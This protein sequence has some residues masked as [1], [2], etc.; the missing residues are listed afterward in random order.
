MFSQNVTTNLPIANLRSR[1]SFSNSQ[2]KNK[3]L[4]KQVHVKMSHWS[5]IS[6]LRRVQISQR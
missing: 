6:A 5:W 4:F 2:T 1:S 3:I